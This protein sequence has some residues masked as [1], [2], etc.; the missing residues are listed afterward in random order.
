M[1]RRYLRTVRVEL[2]DQFSTI[3]I[4]D[5]LIRFDIRL[6][7]TDTPPSGQIDILNPADSTETRIRE[8]ATKFKLFAGYLYTPPSLLMEGEI[9]RVERL[10]EGLDRVTRIYLGG[11]IEA[12]TTATFTKSYTKV[13]LREIVTDLV[14]EMDGVVLGALN[15]IPHNIELEDLSHDGPAKYYL[16]ARLKPFGFEWYED[17]GVI[18]FRKIPTQAQAG[19]PGGTGA[20]TTPAATP[21]PPSIIISEETGMIGSP[22]ITDEGVRV[23][24]LL[25]NRLAPGVRF[26][27]ESDYLIA[28]ERGV[29][30]STDTFV[31]AMVG[32]YGDNWTG[33]FYTDVDGRPDE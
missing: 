5:L 3:V 19:Q 30:V 18:K 10:R 7:G 16:S 11:A 17:N 15:A 22:T 20:G 8:R 9:R 32:H 4:E 2:T 28:Y 13:T 21:A 25:D 23:T 12:I 29:E 1:T 31:A 27:V 6:D 33:S 24:T 26:K 14:A